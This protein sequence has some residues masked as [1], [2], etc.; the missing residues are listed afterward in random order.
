MISYK[1]DIFKKFD[2]VVK[3]FDNLFIPFSGGKDSGV[4]INLLIEYLKDKKIKNKVI[5]YHL[6]YEIQYPQTT[7]YIEK[8]LNLLKKYLKFKFLH[9]CMPFK[10][11]CSM[12]IFQTYWKPWDVGKK[13][14]WIRA[15]PKKSIN[16]YNHNFSFWD[17]SLSDFDFNKLLLL[18][19]DS[20]LNGQ[21]CVFS[22]F[23][24]DEC[25]ECKSI[26]KNQNIYTFYPLLKLSSSDIFDLYEKNSYLLNPIYK[27]FLAL[28]AN[29]EYLKE[30][31]SFNNNVLGLLKYMKQIEY[32]MWEKTLKRVYGVD[33]TAKYYS[34]W[35]FG[36]KKMIPKGYDLKSFINFLLNT[37][38]DSLREN[39]LS[40]FRI[41]ASKD[42]L[43]YQKMYQTLLSYNYNKKYQEA[44]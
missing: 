11:Q 3:N 15:L 31:S 27:I 13:D 32:K 17:D 24:A 5:I 20:M 36:Y 40:K 7:L 19:L 4:I 26:T 33:F 8:M 21:S 42:E 9:I 34:Q 14:L 30:A 2:F 41:L 6:D 44:L 29:K 1:E 18:Y 10:A 16:I 37:F 23:R 12:S 25:K 22:G 35:T 28:G 43:T 39:F 38:D